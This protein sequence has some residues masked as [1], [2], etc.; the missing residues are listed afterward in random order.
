MQGH[1]F[2]K[3]KIHV[4]DMIPIRDFYL[5]ESNKVNA[6]LPFVRTAF[7]TVC[8]HANLAGEMFHT[9]EQVF[10]EG[11]GMTGAHDGTLQLWEQWKE[12]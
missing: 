3:Q 4:R 9:L 6:F 12:R 5:T 10:V 1:L 11:Q 7:T 8:K 2:V